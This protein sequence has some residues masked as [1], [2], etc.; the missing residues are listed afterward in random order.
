MKRGFSKKG[1]GDPESINAFYLILFIG[2]FFIVYLIFLP[3]GE[4]DRIGGTSGPIY[5][6][7]GKPGGT[8]GPVE[9]EILFSQSIGTLQPFGQK[10]YA[11]PLASVNLYA[12]QDKDEELL[13]KSLDVSG[14]FF[15]GTEKE[16]IFKMAQDAPADNVRLLLFL[17]KAQGSI[18]ISL[19]DREIFSGPLTTAQIPLSLPVSSLRSVNRLTFS[20]PSSGWFSKN[21]YVLR[22]VTIFRTYRIEHTREQRTFVLSSDDLKR[23]GHLSLFYI[24]NCFTANEKGTLW[25]TLNGKLISQQQI[26][27]DA[28]EVS[29]DLAR[30]DL[31]E[32][33][34]VLEFS[35]DGGKY[36]LERML[37]EGD[38]DSGKA[39]GYFFGIPVATYDA[40]DSL[41]SI[42]MNLQLSGDNRRKVATFFINGYPLYLDTY[43]D[44]FSFDISPYVVPGQNSLRIVAETSFDV[45][46]L[47]IFL[48]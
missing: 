13:S 39:P 10:V 31:R 1:N 47:D 32:G 43:A 11:K 5:G 45:A 44:S 3:E 35:I 48:E 22:D 17:D 25:I 34:N 27:C 24:V 9:R 15:S 4:K 16:L 7:G 41:G 46:S 8:Y 37:L 38:I 12:D 20:V 21:S 33:R 29:H 28:G 30:N 26:V 36:I 14:G 6:D 2:I 40:L 19:N 42:T 23:F 18:T